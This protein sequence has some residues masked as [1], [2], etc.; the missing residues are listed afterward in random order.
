MFVRV[1]IAWIKF[2]EEHCNAKAVEIDGVFKVVPVR[3][4]NCSF[5]N[6]NKTKHCTPSSSVE[7]SRVREVG[8]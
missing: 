1:V 4:G 7:L 3:C 6:T 8:V 5:K 2:M